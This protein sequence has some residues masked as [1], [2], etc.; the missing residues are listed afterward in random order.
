MIGTQC[1][2]RIHAQPPKVA[3]RARMEKAKSAVSDGH[4]VHQNGEPTDRP[5]A[6]WPSRQSLVAAPVARPRS[7]GRDPGLA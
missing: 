5:R 4:N 2:P 7:G 1:D 3:L 6:P